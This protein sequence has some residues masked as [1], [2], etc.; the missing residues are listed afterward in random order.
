M[1]VTM[2]MGW[3]Y[4]STETFFMSQYGGKMFC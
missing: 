4:F 2:L 3:K 1:S